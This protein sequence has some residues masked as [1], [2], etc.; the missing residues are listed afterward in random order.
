VHTFLPALE[1]LT[2][3]TDLSLAGQG[4]GGVAG[5]AD[6]LVFLQVAVL[7]GCL[8]L[9]QTGRRDDEQVTNQWAE[10]VFG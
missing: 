9:S 3:K 10:A 5:E 2:E 4:I 6:D 1:R 8:V 7:T